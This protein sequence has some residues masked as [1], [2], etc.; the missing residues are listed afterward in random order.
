ML[1]TAKLCNSFNVNVNVKIWDLDKNWGKKCSTGQR[2]TCTEV[3]SYKIHTLRSFPSLQSKIQKILNA[4]SN[5]FWS[6]LWLPF[7][8][9][10]RGWER[11]ALESWIPFSIPFISKNC[12]FHQQA[13]DCQDS[14]AY[15]MCIGFGYNEFEIV[16]SI[17]V[18]RS[19]C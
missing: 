4:N 14:L 10:R 9:K 1:C 16:F 12:V 17:K 6:P 13:L 7:T 5:R 2:F 19:F 18:S 3:T 15:V 8:T 11:K